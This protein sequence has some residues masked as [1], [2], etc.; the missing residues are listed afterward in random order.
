[1]CDSIMDN[2]I[3]CKRQTVKAAAGFFMFVVGPMYEAYE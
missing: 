3:R 1:V 2:A